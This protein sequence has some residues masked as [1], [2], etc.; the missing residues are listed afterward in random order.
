VIS[1]FLCFSACCRLKTAI[2]LILLH[3]F[4]KVRK[5]EN[6]LDSANDQARYFTANLKTV[7]SE[8]ARL[9]EVEQHYRRLRRHLGGDTADEK[10]LEVNWQ[11]QEVATLKN[12]H[13]QRDYMR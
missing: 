6:S 3:F 2:R 12:Q 9:R 1:P 11:E 10:I 8:N 5:L 4:E 7:G 13:I